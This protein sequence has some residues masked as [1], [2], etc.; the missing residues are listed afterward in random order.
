MALPIEGITPSF[1]S[2]QGGTY[3]LSRP[4]YLY[5]KLNDISHHANRALYVMEF[6]SPDAVGETGYLRKKG[7]IPLLEQKEIYERARRLL[8]AGDAT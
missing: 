3:P 5:I 7:L 4:L 2:I 8:L 6:T 1:L